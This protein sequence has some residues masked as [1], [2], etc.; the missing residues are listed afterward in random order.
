MLEKQ[1]LLLN[2]MNNNVQYLASHSELAGAGQNLPGTSMR[3]AIAV[4]GI[5]YPFFQK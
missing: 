5:L 4:I 2:Q 3:M 1:K